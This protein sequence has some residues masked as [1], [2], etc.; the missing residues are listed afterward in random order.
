MYK[1]F[2]ALE[3]NP[4]PSPKEAQRT[5]PQN[6]TRRVRG[7][8]DGGIYMH[9]PRPIQLCCAQLESHKKKSSAENL[10]I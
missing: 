8:N 9:A 7:T 4:I 2:V 6:R 3:W 10:A 1:V 5:G